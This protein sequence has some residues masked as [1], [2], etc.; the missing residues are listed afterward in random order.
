MTGMRIKVISLEVELKEQYFPVKGNR[1]ISLSTLSN[2]LKQCISCNNGPL[3][4]SDTVQETREGFSGKIHIKCSFCSK[5][6]GVN[7]LTENN[8]A[9][10]KNVNKQAVLGA[11]HAGMGR[12]QLES[13]MTCLEVPCLSTSC[14]KDTENNIVGPVLEQEAKIS[15]KKVIEEEL[16]LTRHD[17]KGNDGISVSFDQAWQKRG[18]ALNSKSGHSSVIGEKAGKIV[19]Y[20]VKIESCRVCDIAVRNSTPPRQH[21]CRKITTVHQNLWSKSLQ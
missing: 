14:F 3:Q 20:E 19:D 8:K 21:N 18:K 13:I 15:W 4:L 6:N 16:L 9:G 5:V 1:I 17:L 2:N 12:S 7:T 11:V 10:P